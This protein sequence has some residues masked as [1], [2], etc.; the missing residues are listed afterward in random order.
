MDVIDMDFYQPT[1]KE[2]QVWKVCDS[3]LSENKR[4]TYQSIG[5]HLLTMGLKRG[6]NSD[7]CRY[8]ASWKK[9]HYPKTKASSKSEKSHTS[10][11]NNNSKVNQS[12]LKFVF[13]SLKGIETS[14]QTILS[15]VND[16]QSRPSDEYKAS[17][18]KLLLKLIKEQQ[19]REQHYLAALSHAREIQTLLKAQINQY[20]IEVNELKTK[21]KD[22]S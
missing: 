8:L 15:R 21:F 10:S 11:S 14:Q 9:Y 3:L 18:T 16:I 12:D 4:I 1:P 2:I 17:N 7:I 13:E 5:E 19:V 6:S 22:K 20:Q